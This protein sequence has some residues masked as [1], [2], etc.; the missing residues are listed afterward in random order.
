M[1]TTV[2][3]L[4]GLDCPHCAEKI[5]ASV[6]KLESVREA[7]MDFMHKKLRVEHS[8][9]KGRMLSQVEKIV[10]SFE[11][12]VVVSESGK[13]SEAPKAE[14]KENH[15]FDIVKIILSAVLFG[16]SFLFEGVPQKVMLAAAYLIVGYEVLFEAVRNIL[17]GRPFDENFL[18]TVASLGAMA[19]GEMNESVAVMLFYQIGEFFQSVAVERSRK[20][21]SGLLELKPEYANLKGEGEVRKVS[22]EEVCIGDIILVKPGERVPLDGVLVSGEASLDTSALTGESLPARVVPGGEVLSGSINLNSVIELKVTQKFSDSTV[23]RL[24]DMVQNSSAKKAKTERFI[25]RFARIYTPAVVLSAVLLALVP[26]AVGGFENW[27]MW[28]H[29]ALIFLVISC[30]CALVISV[31]MSF[32]AGIGAASR[33]GILIKGAKSIEALSR[34]RT[35]A[36]DKTGTVTKGVFRVQK[37]E[38][39]NI[40]EK[41]LL[42]YASA[43]ESNSTHPIARSITEC[44][45]A[46]AAV[47]ADS[48]RETAGSGVEAEVDGKTVLCGNA[49]LLTNRGIE[50]PDAENEGMTAVYVAVDGKYAGRILLGDEIKETSS[51]AV[52]RLKSGG[53]KRIVMLTGDKREIAEKVGKAVGIEDVRSELLPDGKVNE[54]EK[55]IGDGEGTVAFAG[56]GINDAPVIARADVGIAMGGL[57][58]DAAIEAADVVLMNDDI[59][60]LSDAVNISRKTMR[61]VRQNIIFALGV[62]ALI[63]LLGAL[64]LTGMWAAVFADVGVS[65]IAILNALRAMRYSKS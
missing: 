25:T 46:E 4:E 1:N 15:V 57:G 21:I 41:D 48:V 63:L 45:G 35:I 6:R 59:T 61:I 42:K 10:K 56:D 52:K 20:S 3:T 53:V 16:L 37:L 32:F 19:V 34:C 64:G 60:K 28:L 2:I 23:S 58:S 24:L 47:K 17:K 9:D 51:H 26:S 55:L 12:D 29:R 31:P 27:T 5:A 50:L 18:M 8:G 22:P 33:N 11:P 39:Y 7:E 65:L 44:A 13:A 36:F 14:E 38:P 49:G 43:A 62:K 30:P 40:S 54:I